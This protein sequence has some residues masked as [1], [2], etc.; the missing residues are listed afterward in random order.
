[1]S[2]SRGRPRLQAAG[3]LVEGMGFSMDGYYD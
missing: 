3:D 2:N 1:V